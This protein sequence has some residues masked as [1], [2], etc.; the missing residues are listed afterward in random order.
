MAAPALFLL[1]LGSLLGALVAMPLGTFLVA[2]LAEAGVTPAA[3]GLYVTSGSACAIAARVA[4]GLLADRRGG[5][6]GWVVA[7]LVAGA[8]GFAVMS[9]G[10]SAAIG[11]GAIL[12]F[13]GA[14]GWTGLFNFAVARRSPGVVAATA[15]TMLSG[16]ALGSAIGPLLFGMLVERSSYATGWLA[17]AVLALCA[18][19]AILVA[20]RLSPAP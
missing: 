18:A 19:A 1:A 9:A 15:G 10:G 7:M 20:R 4:T 2:A 6:L 14:W 12:A 11:L 3:A 5:D 16:A 8:G 17:C 13:G